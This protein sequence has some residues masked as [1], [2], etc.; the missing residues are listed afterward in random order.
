MYI[1]KYIVHLLDKNSDTPVLNDF[2]G[3]INQEVDKF[4]QTA[5]K[6]VSRKD[7]TK[8][9]KYINY[10]SN[11]I[12]NCCEGII[13]DSKNFI[14]NSKEIASCLFDYIKENGMASCDLIVALYTVK[15]EQRVAILTLDFKN[16]YTHTVEFVNDKFSINVIENNNI[17]SNTKISNAA[18]IGLSGMNDEY[19]FTGF[20]TDSFVKEYLNS[21]EVYDDTYKTKMFDVVTNYIL[22]NYTTDV[23]ECLD[24]LDYRNYKLKEKDVINVEEFVKE[25]KNMDANIVVTTALEQELERHDVSGEFEVNKKYIEKK[26]KDR[27]IKTDTGFEIK[28]KL[29][30]AQDPMKFRI[31]QNQDGS[32]D[33]VI[34]N[35]KDIK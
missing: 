23:K 10:N 11:I 20:G 4:I 19:D 34:R 16:Q 32:Y 24:T 12:K 30:D 6:K 15:D 3:K 31:N 35:I 8:K 22:T 7:D 14:E 18:I 1:N 2:E 28:A 25:M 13:Y 27:K 21:N 5:I 17:I 26:L 33:L 9:F 29:S